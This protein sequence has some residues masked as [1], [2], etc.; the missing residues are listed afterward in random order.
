ML[1]DYRNHARSALMVSVGAT[2]DMNRLL[3]ITVTDIGYGGVG[4]RAQRMAVIG[5]VLT[6]SLLLPGARRMIHVEARVI[7]NRDFGRMGC[8]VVRIP[9]VDL[10]ILHTWLKQKTVVKEPAVPV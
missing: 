8:E 10:D 6:F 2:D 5:S 4:L 9:A 1:I 3:P 7:C